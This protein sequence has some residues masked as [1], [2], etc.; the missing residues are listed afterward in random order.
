MEE[1]LRIL[2][3]ILEITDDNN[4]SPIKIDDVTLEFSSN[5]YSSKKNSI[6]HISL[7][8]KHLSKRDKFNIKYKCLTCDS[9]HIVGTTQ[10]IRKV[11]KC[12]YRCNLC[13]NQEINKRLNHSH[14]MLN[15][16]VTGDK[17]TNT[18]DTSIKHDLSYLSLL[19]MRDES[20]KTFNDFDEEF[21]NN[22]YS[23]HLTDDDFKRISG[24]IISI[25]N[26]KY[27]TEDLEYWPVFKTNNQMLFSSIFYD[28][29]NNIVLKAN[30]PIL[31]CDNCN[32]TWRAKKLE[33]FKNCHKIMCSACVCCNKTFKIR[34][35]KNCVNDQVMY[36][37]KLELK[38]IHW[39]NNNSIVVKNGPVLLYKEVKYRV[40]FML[41]DILIDFKKND[42]KCEAV[43]NAIKNGEY[44][45]YYLITPDV[46]NTTL[47][48]IKSK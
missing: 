8:G 36:Q 28:K 5:K 22:Y 30:Q 46:W 45:Q 31:R 47:K 34:T 17:L 14:Y 29:T 21:K 12:S 19:E 4:N 26:G 25:Q 6:Y 27:K 3:N 16:E 32:N 24:N 48:K 35:T 2:D 37:S 23:Y 7:N 38:F 13:C 18:K 42:I 9:I 44:K 10:F 41:N 15:N 11:N 39:C 33:T 1:R 43:N 40:D 20:V